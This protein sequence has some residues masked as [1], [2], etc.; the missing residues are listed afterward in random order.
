MT[1]E[2]IANQ[3][4]FNF[5]LKISSSLLPSLEEQV[6]LKSAIKAAL[7]QRDADHA[8]EVAR[9]RSHKHPLENASDAIRQNQMA[10]ITA[11]RLQL[12]NEKADNECLKAKVAT[13]KSW[14]LEDTFAEID[15]VRAENTSLLQA[16][17]VAVEALIWC[18]GSEDFNEGGKAREGW[19]NVAQPALASCSRFIKGGKV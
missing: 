2:Q 16:V 14:P 8:A 18:S 7:D 9:L 13:F 12:R 15:R 3:I 11:L 4:Y 19:V 6:L 17:G 5:Y 10:E 1:N